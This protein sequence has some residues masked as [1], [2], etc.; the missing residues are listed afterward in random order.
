VT[1]CDT[2][3]GSFSLVAIP[4]PQEDVQ[5]ADVVV[6]VVVGVSNRRSRC[7]MFGHATTCPRNTFGP[8]SKY[9]FMSR[10]TKHD[11]MREGLSLLVTKQS[12]LRPTATM[13][14]WMADIETDVL[15]YLD[16]DFYRDIADQH[17][18]TIK[19][20]VEC[21]LVIARLPSLSARKWLHIL[22]TQIDVPYAVVSAVTDREQNMEMGRDARLV[23]PV[24]FAILLPMLKTISG[25][26]QTFNV[27]GLH[28]VRDPVPWRFDKAADP[29]MTPTAYI[30]R[31]L[32]YFVEEGMKGFISATVPLEG[33]HTLLLMIRRNDLT[34]QH[35]ASL[36]NQYAMNLAWVTVCSEMYFRYSTAFIEQQ[37]QKVVEN[38]KRIMGTLF[39]NSIKY[40]EWRWP[41]Y[42]ENETYKFNQL[43]TEMHLRDLP[44]VVILIFLTN[45][46]SMY[47]I[48]L[49]E[50]YSSSVPTQQRSGATIT[51]GQILYN[52]RRLFKHEGMNDT[53][54]SRLFGEDDGMFFFLLE[55]SIIQPHFLPFQTSGLSIAARL[56]VQILFVLKWQ[57]VDENVGGAMDYV[58]AVKDIFVNDIVNHLG[59]RRPMA[60]VTKMN[61][62]ELFILEGLNTVPVY[63][64]T[65]L[66]QLLGDLSVTTSPNAKQQ[67]TNKQ[68][69]KKK[70][71]APTQQQQ[72]QQQQVDRSSKG[73]G[74]SSSVVD[75][76]QKL[77]LPGSVSMTTWDEDY[78]PH[79]HIHEP[80]F[81]SQ[82]AFKNALEG[83]I[84]IPGD[85]LADPAPK[86]C[87]DKYRELFFEA[88]EFMSRINVALGRPHETPI[89]GPD[90][91]DFMLQGHVL[92]DVPKRTVLVQDLIYVCYACIQACKG[93]KI[94]AVDDGHAKVM[95]RVA[96]KL[97]GSF[98]VQYEFG[99]VRI[100][101][102]KDAL[103]PG[104]YLWIV[105]ISKLI[106]RSDM[107][108]T[109]PPRKPEAALRSFGEVADNPAN[110]H[111]K[112]LWEAVRLRRGMTGDQ[113]AQFIFHDDSV[114]ADE[115]R[116]VMTKH[117]A[118]RFTYAKRNIT[119]EGGPRTLLYTSVYEMG[120]V[121]YQGYFDA[122]AT[123]TPCAAAT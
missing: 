72:Q 96:G 57:L 10:F 3:K 121:A 110:Y 34:V 6:V 8:F 64:D 78:T 123:F 97:T 77:R 52:L 115:E 59:E 109:E 102:L 67:G 25:V 103:G 62:F 29:P 76:D 9:F 99:N 94:V 80:S 89:T 53:I 118:K 70:G 81:P 7:N 112:D 65:Y 14:E 21:L 27:N 19:T 75:D 17:Q 24:P 111:Y 1:R 114:F 48:I 2:K 107:V 18:V 108:V 32:N 46:V 44:G 43:D 11:N 16:H 31:L 88:N 41:D 100:V 85:G 39:Y 98:P 4:I 23:P 55:Q 122:A 63:S 12:K 40:I 79:N 73:K 74:Q 105:D 5:C 47:L 22:G 20:Y 68:K 54:I 51:T 36:L 116:G 90:V 61:T 50:K 35:F 28:G 26:Y 66:E 92:G 84:C 104:H 37:E 82:V 13:K 33:I 120:V 91:A 93:H 106:I 95:S 15:K 71:Q 58:R 45:L 119:S 117:L 101:D 86:T 113:F 83:S 30:A 42:L 69:K 56:W 87:T 49:R 60:Q 38:R